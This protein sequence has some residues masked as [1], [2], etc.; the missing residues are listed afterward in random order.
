VLNYK[1]QITN[2][3]RITKPKYRNS[4]QKCLGF[5]LLGNCV[6]F[7][8]SFLV[9]GI[10]IVG[11]GSQK[12]SVSKPTITVWHWMTDRQEAF[13]ELAKRYEQE[14]GV[15]VNFELYAPSDA[16]SQ[17]IRASAQGNT[18]PDIYGLLGEKRDFAAF[19]ISGHVANLTPYMDENDFQWRNGFFEKALD[20]V[21]FKE[22]NNYG[23]PA[24]VYGAP[25]EIMN[26]QMLYN[27]NLFKKA[28][29]NPDR[30]P[31]TWEEFMDDIEKLKSVGIKGLVSG[32]GEIWMIDCFASNYAFNIMGEDKVMA[33]LRGDVSYTDP[34]WIKVF[35]LFKELSDRDALA[36]GTVIMKN[37]VAEQA[38]ANE[39]AA[40][41]FN[42]S[43]CINVYTGMNPHLEYSAF[44]PPKVN[45][46][47]P[48]YIWGGGSSFSLLVNDRSSK[49]L[50]AIKFLRWLT[51]KDQQVY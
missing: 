22:G 43:W 21:S 51:D 30:P 29:L 10:L 40:F 8:I 44:L 25:I 35:S 12:E 15:K 39:R 23:V 14:C 42:G 7:V 46:K 49:K 28:G 11:C 16:Y 47:N 6:L 24:G 33:T 26:I 18:L 20:V 45:R 9:I 41:A 36:S 3:K 31:K 32:W 1:S 17:K 19:I 4:K 34:D 13:E 50:E 2:S 37:K 27:K 48:M 38:F 5:W